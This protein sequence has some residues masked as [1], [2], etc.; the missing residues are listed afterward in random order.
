MNAFARRQIPIRSVFVVCALS[1][2]ACATTGS[3][4]RVDKA[5]AFDAAQC[6]SF[7]WHSPSKEPASFTEQR[8]RDHVMSTLKAKGYAEAAE[9]PGCRVSYVLATRETPKSRPGVGVGVGG[10]S[11]GLGGGIGVTLPVGRK[12][13]SGTF[14]LD[15]IDSTK[16]AQVWSGSIDSAFKSAELT[17]DEAR[18][19]VEQ[20]LAAF[21][22]RRPK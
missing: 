4:V 17:D 20:V 11:G 1:L 14:T 3:Q 18:E 9:N 10:G 13:E 2:G 16:N 21:P 19:V 22:D 6:T 8:V 7:A 12:S 5:D 15:V